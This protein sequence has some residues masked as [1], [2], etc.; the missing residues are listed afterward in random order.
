[1][2]PKDSVT[3]DAADAEVLPVA[4]RC[5]LVRGEALLAGRLMSFAYVGG[6]GAMSF[7][8]STSM[9]GQEARALV[10]GI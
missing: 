3:R 7:A 10:L 4:G 1:M 2:E 8:Q 9:R 6:R 5:A